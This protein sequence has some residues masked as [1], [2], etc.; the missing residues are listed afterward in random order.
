MH[1]YLKLLFLVNDLIDKAIPRKVAFTLQLTSE[2][3]S[4]T[5]V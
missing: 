1:F 2:Q 5:N 3:M 4:E